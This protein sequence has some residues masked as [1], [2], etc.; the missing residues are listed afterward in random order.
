M[1]HDPLEIILKCWFRA[2]FTKQGKLARERNSK[3]APMGGD[4]SEGDLL[5]TAQI[6]EHTRNI[7][8]LINISTNAIYQAQRKLA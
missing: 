2:S 3:T 1:S 6:K 7:Y 5:T 4:I 8:I